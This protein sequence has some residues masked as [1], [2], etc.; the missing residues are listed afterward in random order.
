M[1][2][3]IIRTIIRAGY[4]ILSAISGILIT[5]IGVKMEKHDFKFLKILMSKS[6]KRKKAIEEF[7]KEQGTG[8]LQCPRCKTDK[9]KRVN[10]VATHV[11]KQIYYKCEF[12]GENFHFEDEKVKQM[13]LDKWK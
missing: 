3:K 5:Y 6:Y 9:I 7:E 2:D 11:D 13:Y 1:S 8:I 10:F 4:R 12:C